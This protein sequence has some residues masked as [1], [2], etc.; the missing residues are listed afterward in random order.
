MENK[1]REIIIGTGNLSKID[2]IKQSLSKADVTIVGINEISKIGSDVEETG[3]TASEN[4]RLK[5][6]SYSKMLG[7]PVLSTDAAIFIDGLS[8]EEQPGTRAKRI[9]K[10][11]EEATDE[12]IIN[13]Y[14]AIIKGL[15][16]KTTMKV[17]DAFCIATPD[18]RLFE[19]AITSTRHLVSQPSEKRAEGHP[20]DSFQVDPKT[21]KYLSEMT[22]EEKTVFWGEIFGEKLSKFIKDTLS[23]LEKI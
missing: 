15:G 22:E 13:H 1:K 14:S 20:Q 12:E 6:L 18:G 11:G 9:N 23:Q 17:V 21:G 8:D 19:T 10:K 7:K 2:R 3:E 4:A 5:A 16:D